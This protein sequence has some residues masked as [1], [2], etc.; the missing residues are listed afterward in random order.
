M[1]LLGCRLKER[2]D[3]ETGQARR[4]EGRRGEERRGGRRVPVFMCVCVCV[5]VG[6][7]LAFVFW[8]VK[9]AGRAAVVTVWKV[10]V[11]VISLDVL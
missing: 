4:G 10:F 8:K 3:V 9:R 1:E 5:C 6:V 7:C 11:K 2:W